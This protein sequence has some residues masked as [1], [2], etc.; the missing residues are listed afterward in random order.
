MLHNIDGASD[1]NAFNPV[2]VCMSTV[3]TVFEPV[4][5]TGQ[6]IMSVH[7]VC[8][9]QYDRCVQC[10]PHNIFVQTFSV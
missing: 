8:V 5:G 10:H 7:Y 1:G 3:L 9:F 2:Y 4:F 6:C